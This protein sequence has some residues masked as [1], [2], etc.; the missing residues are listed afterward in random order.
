MRQDLLLLLE[1]VPLDKWAEEIEDHLDRALSHRGYSSN[2][3]VDEQEYEIAKY[4]VQV[5]RDC[6]KAFTSEQ[7]KISA[8]RK[9]INA[10]WLV[11]FD[12]LV[13]KCRSVL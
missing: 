12:L 9:H 13:T 11:E 5:A 10:T 1:Y 4:F 2:A 7:S 3:K 8:L 6:G